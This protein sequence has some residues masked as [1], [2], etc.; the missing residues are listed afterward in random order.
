LVFY[1][2][3]QQYANGR[4]EWAVLFGCIGT[5]LIYAIFKSTDHSVHPII[6]RSKISDVRYV[7]PIEGLAPPIIE[8]RFR[9]PNGKKKKRT[10]ALKFG[11]EQQAIT[12]LKLE[13][14]MG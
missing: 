1:F 4:T 9:D 12:V 7:K 11:D 10:V 14:L 6:D 13:G 8:I 3:W 2:A 5:Y